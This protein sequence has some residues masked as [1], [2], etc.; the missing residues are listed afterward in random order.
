MDWLSQG[1]FGEVDRLRQELDQKNQ[2]IERLRSS[3]HQQ[4]NR[5]VQQQNILREELQDGRVPDADSL[6]DNWDWN[7]VAGVDQQAKEKEK[8]SDDRDE[9]ITFKSKK[10]MDDY[11]NRKLQKHEQTKAQHIVESQQTQAQ[12]IEKFA[13]E[14]PEL[15]EHQ[16][17]VQRLW[18]QSVRLNPNIPADQ[19]FSG[20]VNE[21]KA[22]LGNYGL[23]KKPGEE[24]QQ[25]QQQDRG[26]P[27]MGQNPLPFR[28]M[29]RPM[30]ERVD[31]YDQNQH[32]Q[33]LEQRRQLQRSKM[34]S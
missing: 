1:E 24:G 26:I 28:D 6:L 23:I 33:E 9:G 17:T 22:I 11:F 30:P 34:F 15:I 20:V 2:E 4:H 3:S 8:V 19:R 29:G 25:R 18:E 31:L 10:A 14:H 13:K 27:Y 21:T 5:S 32:R 16:D 12:L 7:K